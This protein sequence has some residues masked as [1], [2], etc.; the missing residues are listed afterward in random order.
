M[1]L[2]FVILL[3]VSSLFGYGTA[4]KWMSTLEDAKEI[5]QVEKKPIL[6]FIHS[7]ACFYCTVLEEK[8]F[9]DK[10]LQAHL[11]KDFVLLALDGSTDADAFEGQDGQAPPRYITSVTP[12][13][14]FIGPDEEKLGGR[15]TKHMVIYGYWTIEELKEWSDDAIKKFQRYY[16]EKYAK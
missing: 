16:G 11:K 13:F 1:R 5:A 9:P 2:I 6:L 10:E 14:F 3:F 12:A 15:G 7:T 8:V 4:I